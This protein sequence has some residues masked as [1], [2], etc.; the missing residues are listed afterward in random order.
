[1]SVAEMAS[2]DLFFYYGQNL[3]METESELTQ[4]LMSPTGSMM[5]N[6]QYGAGVAEFENFPNGLYLQIMLRYQISAAVAYRNS[7][8]SY[9][10]NGLLDRRIAVSQNFMSFIQSNGNLDVNVMYFMLADYSS[11]KNISLPISRKT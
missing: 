11:L 3:S 10:Q 7:S 4:L 1:M 8:V 6:R 9:G 2:S 5:Y